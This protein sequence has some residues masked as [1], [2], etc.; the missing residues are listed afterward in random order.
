[1]IESRGE[2][3]P[4]NDHDAAKRWIEEEHLRRFLDAYE[5]VTEETFSDIALSE[6]PDFI[7]MDSEGRITGIE[8]TQ[9]RFS[10]DVQSMRR[11]FE[12]PTYD[13]E[14]YMRLIELLHKK[15]Q[16][17]GKGR[18]HECQ[19]KI[20]VIM[21]IDTTIDAIVAGAETD[22]PQPGGFD[23]V[24]LADYTQVE[25]FD[26]VDL[27]VLVHKDLEGHFATGDYGQKPYG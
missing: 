18:W 20:L 9:I 3:T 7:A 27:F 23:E 6:T 1:M 12:P 25:A 8:L 22:K 4:M 11:I 13:S 21:L 19:R 17:L 15:D 14:S 26:G 24:W 2:A 10:P 16:T 5:E